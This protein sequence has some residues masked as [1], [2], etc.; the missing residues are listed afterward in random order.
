M[1]R[2]GVGDIPIVTMTGSESSKGVGNKFVLI[3]LSV[4][5]VGVGEVFLTSY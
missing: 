2:C 3:A 4:P 1:R 5:I